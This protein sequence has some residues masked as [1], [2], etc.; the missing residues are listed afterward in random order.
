MLPEFGDLRLI[1]R[2]SALKP[3]SENPCRDNKDFSIDGYDKTF[4]EDERST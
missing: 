1:G 2:R 4:I 3:F